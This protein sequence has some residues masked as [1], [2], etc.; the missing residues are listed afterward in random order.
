MALLASKNPAGSNITLT[1]MLPINPSAWRNHV[2]KFR[3]R[4]I[5]IISV[6]AVAAIVVF[7]FTY[8]YFYEPEIRVTQASTIVNMFGNFSNTNTLNKV[9]NS[10]NESVYID[11]SGFKQS[12]FSVELFTYGFYV[13]GPNAFETSILIWIGGE[14]A[15]DMHPSTI[16]LHLDDLASQGNNSDIAI[17]FSGIQSGYIFG[18]VNTN[19]SLAAQGSMIGTGHIDSNVSL[20]NQIY[21]NFFAPTN[22]NS[23]YCFS[24][25]LEYYLSIYS[26]YEFNQTHLLHF[27]FT[28]NGLSK[29]VQI[30][31]SIQFKNTA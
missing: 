29:S 3:R 1:L 13:G 6:V 17:Q 23:F 15:P 14:L 9:T 4:L 8:P 10:T 5:V 22:K 30:M 26:G 16:V 18:H 28:M 27:T 11:Q 21:S 31:L 12:S 7:S 20:H 19:A 2:G 25:G 24:I